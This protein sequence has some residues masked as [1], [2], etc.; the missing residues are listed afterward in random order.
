[1]KYHFYADK[2]RFL[3]EDGSEIPRRLAK[4]IRKDVELQRDI[5]KGMSRINKAG[6]FSKKYGGMVGKFVPI[7]AVVGVLYSTS[8]YA[9]EICQASRDYYATITQAERAD[10]MDAAALALAAILE[11]VVE[12]AGR[13]VIAAHLKDVF[14]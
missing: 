9:E 4:L 13:G 6:G 8:A 5:G 3:A 10:E 2:G 7:L 12:G 14:E 1:M 11:K